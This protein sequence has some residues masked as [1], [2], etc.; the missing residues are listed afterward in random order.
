MD[1]SLRGLG[2]RGWVK[3]RALGSLRAEV[4]A[5]GLGRHEALSV[6]P[7]GRGHSLESL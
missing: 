6:D 5:L 7:C 2:R 1:E 4:R 3:G